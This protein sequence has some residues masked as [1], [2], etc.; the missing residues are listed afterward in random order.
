MKKTDI[1][2]I[3]MAS[4]LQFEKEV[5][6]FREEESKGKNALITP[7]KISLRRKCSKHF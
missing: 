1:H 6:N 4:S 3:V 2:A 7:W 5:R